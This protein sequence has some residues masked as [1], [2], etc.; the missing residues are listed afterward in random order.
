MKLK[1][2]I[3]SFVIGILIISIGSITIFSYIEMKNLLRDQI[4]KNMLN[5]ANSFASTYEVKEYLKGNKTV[6]IGLLN[7]EIEKARIKTGVEFIVVMDMEGIRYSHPVKSKIGEKFIGGDEQRVLKDGEEYISTASGSLGISVRAFSPI[8]DDDNKQIGAVAVGML[9][10]KFDNEVYT[11]MYKFIP[12]IVAGL[13][14]G[15]LGAVAIS[16][17]IKKAIFGLEPEEIALILKQKETVIENIK[18]GIIALDNN[19]RITLF[20]EE[21]SRIL[22]LKDSDIGSPITEFTYDSMLDVFLHSGKPIRNVEIKARPGLNIMCKYST[23]KGFKNQ[24]LGLVVTFEDLTEVR[25]MA[26]ELTG[27]KKMAWSLRAQNHEFMNKL[28]TI[29]GLIQLEEYD[30]AVKF[31]NVIADSKKNISTIISDKIKDVSLAALILAKY[32][33]CEEYRI[34]LIIDENSKLTRLPEY[35]TSEELVSVVGNLIENSIDEVKKDGT[36]EIYVKICEE[37]N[38]INI[39]IKDN[40]AGI[41]ESIR[42]SIYKIGITTKK[43]SR[44]F[45]MHIVKKIIDEA[46]GN[47]DFKINRG[48]EWIISIPRERS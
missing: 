10:N 38:N 2:K 31:I 42:E 46:K 45:G 32:S 47:I 20:N 35:M 23:I 40:G 9:Y 29:S 15:A 3:A 26:E 14:L 30:E 13:V 37:E 1:G 8:Y 21:A 28:H 16:Y 19:G 7:D 24:D 41:P 36:G 48:T 17:S 5:I 39:N 44:G 12:I 43:G 34:K 25:K 18:E 11:K 33:K 4:D 27:I 22:G 6:P